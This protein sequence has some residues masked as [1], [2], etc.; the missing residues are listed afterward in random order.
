MVWANL[1]GEGRTRNPS[2]RPKRDLQADFD[3]R[4]ELREA[5]LEVRNVDL[6]KAVKVCEERHV[7]VE[8]SESSYNSFDRVDDPWSSSL[9]GR[10][11]AE[12]QYCALLPSPL[13]RVGGWVGGGR[14]GE[15][16]GGAV[17]RASLSCFMFIIRLQTQRTKITANR[18]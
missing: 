13:W 15:G 5:L 8:W 17:I 14:G 16:E 6:H 3:K 12:L 2:F 10:C 11:V 7:T 4:R 9:F 18:M 1:C